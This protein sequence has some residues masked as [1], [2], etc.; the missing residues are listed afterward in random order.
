MKTW[1][2]RNPALARIVLRLGMRMAVAI[3]IVIPLLPI[4]EQQGWSPNIAA[5]VAVVVGLIVGAKL[6][7]RVAVMWGL[8]EETL[9][10]AKG[11]KKDG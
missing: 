11:E 4:A 6:A 1:A 8:P 9:P 5:I 7:E 2:Q 10:G 3:G